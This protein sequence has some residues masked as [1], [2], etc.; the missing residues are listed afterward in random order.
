MSGEGDGP[1][2][3]GQ[4]GVRSKKSNKF[5]KNQ[6]V[7]GKSFVDEANEKKGKGKE[8]EKDGVQ[9]R[10]PEELVSKRKE[11]REALMLEVKENEWKVMGVDVVGSIAVQV[12]MICQPRS[13]LTI[14]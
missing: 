2:G 11:M 3:Q 5:R 12:S 13:P 14:R 8:K 4:G 10:L 7:K 6:G 9:R 1:Q